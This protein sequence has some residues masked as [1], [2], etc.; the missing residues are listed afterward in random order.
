[1]KIPASFACIGV[2]LFGVAAGQER[3]LTSLPYTPSLDIPSMDRSVDPCIDFYRYSCG[4]WIKTNP[5]PPDQASWDVYGKLHH[6]N[7][8][9]LWGI[10]EQ[11][12][13]PDPSRSKVER[14]I[15]DFFYACMDQAAVEKAGAAPL[16]P[17]LDEI[18]GLKSLKDLT[19]FVAKQHLTS[20]SGDMLFGFASNQDFA[21]SSRVIAFADAGG[22]GLPDRDYYDKTD[23]KS[24]ETRARYLEHLRAMFGLLGDDLKTSEAEAK[25]VMEI[26]TAL[27]KAQLTQVE[28][29]DPYKLFHKVT[30]AQ[31]KAMTP[32]LDWDEYFAIQSAPKLNDLNV[33]EPAFYAELQKQLTSR[34]L[35]D[36]KIYLRWHLVD[37]KAPHLS[38][39]FV[40]T[41]FDFY[42]GYLHGLK[43]MPPRWRRCVQLV[44]S[45]L[46]EALGQVFVEKTFSADAKTRALEMTREIEG[47]MERDLKDLRKSGAT[48][49]LYGSSA[50]ISWATWIAPPPSNR[51]A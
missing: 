6:E 12:A 46:G 34:P 5:I 43:E 37:E 17:A 40:Q 29:R 26:E 33:T 21:D 32:A 4:G 47:A 22:L 38:S 7:M 31:F 44:D 19:R 20:Q 49:V 9:L 1:M 8:R 35:D 25:T 15:G 13:K 11:A 14:Q 45:E 23:A 50:A 27:A 51:I 28:K 10:L 41:D 18:A 36:W 2:F 48:T 42:R 24:V 3:P 39:K 16:K 30:P